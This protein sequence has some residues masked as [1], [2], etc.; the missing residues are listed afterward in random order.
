MQSTTSNEVWK[1]I[2]GPYL[3]LYEASSIGRIR[4]ASDIIAEHSSRFC[5][6]G[7]VRYTR[8]ELMSVTNAADY[9]MV[10]LYVPKSLRTDSWKSTEYVHR[11]VYCAFNNVDIATISQS[12]GLVVDHIDNNHRNNT[13]DNLQLLTHS[14]NTQKSYDNNESNR[15]LGRKSSVCCIETGEVYLTLKEATVRTQISDAALISA[16]R[17]GK[18]AGGYHWRYTDEEKHQYFLSKRVPRYSAGHIRPSTNKSNLVKCIETGEI[19]K[20]S[21]MARKYKCH[22][23]EVIY[24]AIDYND[25]YSKFLNLHFELVD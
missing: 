24:N 21:N 22:T 2:L 18:T 3:G 4:A 6:K 14:Q 7:E 8:H 10:C 9:L 17:H 5:K 16:C 25:G 19:D 11:L 13:I 1:P 23:S 20:V 15:L 12:S